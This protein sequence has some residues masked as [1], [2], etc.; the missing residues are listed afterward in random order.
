MAY[1]HLLAA[2]TAFDPRSIRDAPERFG[3]SVKDLEALP[4]ANQPS[5]VKTRMLP[6]QLQG[7]HWLMKMEHPK[8]PQENNVVQF[9]KRIGTNWLNVATH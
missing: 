5:Q 9:W 4:R 6:Y 1:D 2:S 3:L 7:L 8:L